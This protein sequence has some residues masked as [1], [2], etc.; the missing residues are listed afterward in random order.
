LVKNLKIIHIVGTAAIGGVQNFILALGAHDQL[1]K[2]NRDILCLYYGSSKLKQFF[3]EYNISLFHCTLIL[4]DYG[5]RPYKIWKKIRVF[6]GGLVF[7]IKYFINIERCKADIVICHEPVN[8][9]VQ[10]VVCKCLHIPFVI[11]MHK[12]IDLKKNNRFIKYI[13]KHA[14]FI[15][16]SEKLSLNNFTSVKNLFHSMKKEIPVITA[17]SRIEEIA[18]YCNLPKRTNKILQIGTIGRLTW[19]KNFEQ[20]IVIA[21]KIRKMSNIKFHITIVGTGPEY[22][23]LSKLLEFMGVADLV[24]LAGEKDF[25][26][27]IKFLKNLDIYIQTSISEGSPL[28][29]KEA[30]AA[31][32]P[33]IST[34]ISGIS[35][36]IT[37]GVNG[38]LVD[39]DNQ[40]KFLDIINKLITMGSENRQLIGEK[41]RESILKKYSSKKTA[42]QYANF[43]S[44]LI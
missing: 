26:E 12:E 1:F 4:K 42:E 23:K 24:S 11:H 19:E 25:S 38:F 5:Y 31:S 37:N 9:I 2:I 21:S 27:I 29:V 7:P 18:D 14:F 16:D 44:S 10:L 17:T 39:K 36:L 13:S 33:V 8:L 43:C 40:I 20:V 34:D 32:L 30:M 3:L 22:G 41:A 28:T 15:S 35:D 6:L